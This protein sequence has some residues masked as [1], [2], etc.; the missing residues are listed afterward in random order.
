MSFLSHRLKTIKPSPTLSLT[1]KAMDLRAQGRDIISLGAGEPDFGTPDWIKE[2]AKTALEE[3]K[4][5]YTPVA[6]TP[7]L[8]NAI[9][10]KFKKENALTYTLD[11]I[12]VSTGGKQVIFNAFMASL[13]PGDDVLIPAPYWVSYPDIVSIA[14]GTPC[15]IDCPETE[16]F[17]LSA[18][19]LSKSITSKTKWLVLN[20]PSNPTG[21]VYSQE[22]LLDLAEVLEKHP[23]IWV[24]SDDI[25]E[26]VLFTGK[27][28]RTMAEVAP[29]MKDRTLTLN[30]V[31]KAYA[32]TGW[33]IGYAGGPREL[34]SAMSKLQSQSTSN[35]CS[36]SQEAAEA[37]LSGQQD[38][39]KERARVFQSRRDKVTTLLNSLEGISCQTPEGAFYLY[40]SCQGLIGTITPSGQRLETDS[41][42]C[43]YFLESADVALVP[44]AAFGLSPYF[45]LSYATDLETLEKACER[46]QGAI[47]N[48]RT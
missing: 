26:H 24:L 6:G 2:A 21:A 11:E 3:E 23:H 13:N 34:I 31:S 45:R 43:D 35:P 9:Q 17:K 4:T 15:L 37:A 38:F 29:S 14:G 5:K 10:Q 27:P 39:L 30:G 40:P 12:I 22:E 19:R 16:G 47:K 46:L 28:F 32:M 18:E 20:S 25:Y 36:I 1:R 42:V 8:K 48:L 33:R 7:G 41:D 44:G